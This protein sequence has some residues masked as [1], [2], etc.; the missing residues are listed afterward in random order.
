MN[1]LDERLKKNFF[2]VEW[3]NIDLLWQMKVDFKVYV[4]VWGV[5][6]VRVL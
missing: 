5:I 6:V 4:K 1:I 2:D 3:F